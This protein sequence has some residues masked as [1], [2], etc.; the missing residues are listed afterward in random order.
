[1]SERHFGFRNKRSKVDAFAK[2]IEHI[3]LIPDFFK[4]TC[5]VLL[6][7]TKAFDSVEHNLLLLKCK[8]Y[9][10]RGCI[11]H[12]FK[13]YLSDLSDCKKWSRLTR[14]SQLF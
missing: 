11:H 5:S 2:L 7:L 6:D 8:S 14:R 1:M 10:L 3:K 12:L 9:G 13:S 4:V